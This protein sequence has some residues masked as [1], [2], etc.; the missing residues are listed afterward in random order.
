MKQNTLL[1]WII[2][3]TFVVKEPK[4]V[5]DYEVYFIYFTSNN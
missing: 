1:F 2:I 3:T 5:F 4:K